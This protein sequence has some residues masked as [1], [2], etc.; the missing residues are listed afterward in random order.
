M[1]K[2]GDPGSN[3]GTGEN[4][5]LKL[6]KKGGNLLKKLRGLLIKDI[7]KVKEHTEIGFI[8]FYFH[9]NTQ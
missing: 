5:S 9:R 8:C 4:F 6:T 1:R 3:P 7:N 2:A